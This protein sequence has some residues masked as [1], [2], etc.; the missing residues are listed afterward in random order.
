MAICQ[1]YDDLLERCRSR[2]KQRYAT[3]QVE[4]M[5]I[6]GVTVEQALQAVYEFLGNK[7]D[8]A[9]FMSFIEHRRSRG[10]IITDKNGVYKVIGIIPVN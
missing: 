7:Y 10:W 8:G 4:C 9:A 3:E 6:K 2:K 5:M 1:N